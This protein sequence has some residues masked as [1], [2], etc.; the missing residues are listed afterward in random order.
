MTDVVAE[1]GWGIAFLAG[2]VSF[3]S[4]C[5][6]PLAPGYLAYVAGT[7]LETGAAGRRQ[8]TL[9]A[10]S[11]SVLFMLGF[12]L[13]FVLLGTSVALLGGFFEEHRS[14]M[15][16]V[17]GVAMIVFGLLMM[18]LP[19]IGWLQ[20]EWSV[21]ASPD[22]LGP[23]A[24]VLLGMAFAFAWTPCVGPILG[25]ILFYAGATE[26]AGRGGLLLFVYSLGF[27]IPFILAGLGF[28]SALRVFS[29]VRRH[30]VIVNAVAG[31]LLI[32]VGVLLLMGRWGN[33]SLWFQRAY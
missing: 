30:S 14:T 10:L 3:L 7:T 26:T 18:G 15:Y 31:V 24:P 11:T 29:W 33:L 8:A 19:Q 13:I 28:A 20:R 9:R 32:A 6:A 12:T 21:S 22:I 5:V 4:P 17:A 23:A 1:P 25:S 27:G 2:V 16:H